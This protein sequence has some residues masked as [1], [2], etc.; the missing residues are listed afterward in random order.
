MR[1]WRSIQLKYTFLQIKNT[2]I[3]III[4]IRKKTQVT[5][6]LNHKIQMKSSTINCS[7]IQNLN[8]VAKKIK[9]G[10]VLFFFANRTVNDF[11]HKNSNRA[12]YNVIRNGSQLWIGAD[13]GNSF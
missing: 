8:R 11:I 13:F 7:Q 12:F 4:S 10:L 2:L 3:F 1:M 6:K 5:R 9:Q